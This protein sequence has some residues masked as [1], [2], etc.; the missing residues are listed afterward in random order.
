VSEADARSVGRGPGSLHG[1]VALVTGSAGGIG[2][3][4][5]Q[6]FARE[7]ASVFGVDLRGSDFDADLTQAEAAEAAVRAAVE[8]HGHLDVVFN[9]VGM[10]G[11][12]LGDGP[13]DA[14]AEEAW[15]LVLA[16][17]LKSV[18]LVCK[19]AVPELLRS[20]GGS[21]VNVSSVL[22][23]VGGDE[24]WSTHAYA[25]S[26]GG[27]IALTRAMAATYAKRGIRANVICPAV[28]AT[29]Q[30]S[31]VRSDARLRARLRDLQPLT[32]DLGRAEDVAGAAVYLAGP[33]SR[34][35]TGV[36]LP[37]DGGWTAK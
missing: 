22:G 5:A 9:A 23:M 20:G 1:L 17:N 15:D 27:L 36:V 19:F 24:D 25:A 34:F 14:C 16:T 13:V 6:S 21:I 33:A 29:A 30:G 2:S 37:V 26:K 3:E 28:I 8:R 12:R 10:S 7:G 35:V 32:G 18:Y 11:R 4:T 31:R